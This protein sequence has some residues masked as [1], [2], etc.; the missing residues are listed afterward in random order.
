MSDLQARFSFS[1]N[2]C[3]D[4]ASS[5]ILD[6]YGGKVIKYTPLSAKES[7]VLGKLILAYPGSVAK[8]ALCAAIN[9]RSDEAEVRRVIND[10]KKRHG[11]LK[12]WIP[13]AR[14]GEYRLQEPAVSTGTTTSEPTPA[15]A[16]SCVLKSTGICVRPNFVREA[17]AQ[18][19]EQLDEAFRDSHIVFLQGIGGIG[20]SETAKHWALQKKKEGLFDT[21][22]FAQLNS[23]T[24]NSNVQSLIADD[25]IFV[26]AGVFRSRDE[27]ES[28]ADY[29]H[30]KLAKIKQVTDERTLII[31]DNYDIDDQQM[32]LLFTGSYR[33]LITT[34]NQQSGYDFPIIPV[35]DIQEPQHL[36]EVFFR[37]LGGERDDI[38]LDDPYIEKL[39]ALVSN[40]TLTIEIIAKALINSADTPR[41][42]YRKIENPEQHALIRHVDGVV[43]RNFSEDPL[44]PF[45]YIRRLFSL[46]RLE[47][48]SNF[49]YMAQVLVFMA[50]MPTRGIELSLLNRWSD[51]RII[52]ARN[53]LVRKSWLRQ[54]LING[55]RI[56]SMHPLIREIV[57][58]ELE[59]SLE[60]CSSIIDLFILEDSEYIDF[61]HNQPRNI[62]DKYEQIG[63]SLLSAFPIHDSTMFDFYI[64]L[65]RIFHT[66]ASSPAALQLTKRMKTVLEQENKTSTWQ[67]GY[68][69]YR[70][71][72]VYS[73]IFRDRSKGSAYFQ[74]G[75][76]KMRE[77]ARTNEQKMWLALC[78][79]EVVS[80]DCR[81]EYLFQQ[82]DPSHINALEQLLDSGEA[83]VQE[84]QQN[85]FNKTNL[86]LYF[87]TVCVWRSRIA[88]CR[89][90]FDLATTLIDTAESEFIRFGYPNVLDKAAIADVRALI[91]AMQGAYDRQIAFLK[92]AT[93]V[94]EDGYGE[95]HRSSMERAL[96][97]ATAYQNNNQPHEAIR[98]LRHY[99]K[100]AL[101]MLGEEDN[102]TIALRN[103]LEQLQTPHPSQEV[104]NP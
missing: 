40:H 29:F 95:V 46:S 90:S 53:S 96:T 81:N 65:Q 3:Y 13:R 99:G 21:V 77:L 26:L 33:L 34:R 75:L 59:P 23:E 15:Q 14:D 7:C 36:K 63:L 101:D 80:L 10:L 79:R 86:D 62:K 37:N 78:Y 19:F 6:M 98:V 35:S 61:L 58:S 93:T 1:E 44:S 97:L 104:L 67:Y 57:W 84:L 89:G 54:D 55:Q 68:I 38:S 20:K 72:S 92:E 71:G 60:K 73:W 24:N 70:I 48:D 11:Q 102:L 83:L 4:M 32:A 9:A 31:I 51:S 12:L 30:R 22:V 18:V 2:C 45:E 17:R 5:T 50:A 74:A 85:G 66:C 42:L 27:D 43:E 87:G 94:F 100:V 49:E 56:V 76:E 8:E 25:T 16:P 82:H 64:K 39:F 103:Q 91:C 28:T 88:I 41:T 69:N 52:R 47:Q